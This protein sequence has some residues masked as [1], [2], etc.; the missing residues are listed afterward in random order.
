MTSIS[1]N[2]R[3]GAMR[4][5]VDQRAIADVTPLFLPAIPFGFVLGLAMR[6]SAMPTTVAWATSPLLF[7]GAAQLA[8][9]TLA[10]TATVWAVIV[11]GLVI[12][13][14]HVMYSAALAPVFQQQP[15]WVRWVGSFVLIDQ[16]FAL[17]AM[18]AD[19]PPHEFRRYYLTAGF[20]FY[21]NWQWSTALGLVVGPAV[22]ES[23]RLEYA[24]PIMFVALVLIGIRRVPQG[25]AAFVGGVVGLAT[26]GLPDRLGIL[27]GAV[28]GVAAGTVAEY[29][30]ERPAGSAA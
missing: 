4:A 8:V 11:A 21:L 12:N 7:A 17:A 26:A 14:R 3:L 2:G 15:R 5:G 30:A 23:W 6:E 25:V 29:A 24:P 22:P 16:V 20:F 18:R 9:V 1:V 10:G 19:L 13:T 28:A 27:A